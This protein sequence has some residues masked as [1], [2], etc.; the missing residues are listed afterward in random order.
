MTRK[1][2]DLPSKA[3]LTPGGGPGTEIMMVKT[4]LAAQFMPQLPPHHRGGRHGPD[5]TTP[6]HGLHIVQA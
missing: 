1:S 4:A 3:K 2:G 5:N 6:H